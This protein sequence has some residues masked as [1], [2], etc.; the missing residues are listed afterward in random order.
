MASLK[1][2]NLLRLSPSLPIKKFA[3]PLKRIPAPPLFSHHVPKEISATRQLPHVPPMVVVQPRHRPLEAYEDELDQDETY[4]EVSIDEELMLAELEEDDEDDDFVHP[5]FQAAH[6]SQLYPPLNTCENTKHDAV[7]GIT[8]TT[9]DD[10]ISDQQITLGISAV[11]SPNKQRAT[12][13]S[14]PTSHDGMHL[15]DI[16]GSPTVTTKKGFSKDNVKSPQS[17]TTAQTEGTTLFS[18]HHQIKRVTKSTETWDY[19]EFRLSRTGTSVTD[20]SGSSD[21]TAGNSML[22]N[23]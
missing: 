19:E 8:T 12:T 14:H 1:A 17:R 23:I 10:D 15:W 16:V 4:S 3:S 2:M 13:W 7:W 21:W 18:Q 20:A 9:I 6:W 11:A 5:V 22:V